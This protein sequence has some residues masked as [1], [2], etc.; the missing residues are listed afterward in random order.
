MCVYVC[1]FGLFV[2]R[3]VGI[4]DQRIEYFSSLCVEDGV[5]SFAVNC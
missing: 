3:V 4:D 5:L 1:V 2:F